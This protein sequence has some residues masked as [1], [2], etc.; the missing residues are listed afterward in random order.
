MQLHLKQTPKSVLRSSVVFE[1]IAEFKRMCPNCG[2]VIDNVRLQLGLPCPLCL[3]ERRDFVDVCEALRTSNKLKDLEPLCRLKELS[4]E[5]EA[6]F[7]EKTGFSPWKLQ[8]VWARRVFL[9]RSFSLIAPT[10]VGKSTW[11]LVMSCYIKGRVYILVPTKLL[12]MQTYDRLKALSP[13]K[14]VVAYTGKRTEKEKIFSGDFDILITTTNFLYRNEGKIPKP[15]DFV[16]V[17]D[18]DSL[19]KSAKNIDKVLKLLGFSQE[20][21]SVALEAVKL[22]AALA[23]SSSQV[24][25]R[26]LKK[27][28]EDLNA[29]RK[30][31]KGVLVVSSATSTPRSN[32]VKLFR[33]LLGFEVGKS[34]SFLRNVTDVLV[35]SKSSDELELAYEFLKEQ[36]KGVFIFVSE[37][38]GKPYVKTVVDFL[39]SRGFKV[40]SY[41]DFSPKKQE[42]FKKGL[43]DAV[44]GISSYKNPLARGIDIP[45]ALY[46]ALFIG[47]P[48][49]M[50]S[51]NLDL[52]PSKLF[53]VLLSLR[54]LIS[55]SE[56]VTSYLNFLKKHLYLKESDIDR[57]P[58]VKAE[59]EKIRD[60]LKDLLSQEEFIQKIKNSD[61]VF[62]TK[63]DGKLFLVVGDAVGYLQASGRVSRLFAGGLTKGV[64]LML[65][66]NLKAL[67][68]LKKRLRVFLSDLK[69]KVLDCCDGRELAKKTGL[70]I[71]DPEELKKELEKAKE[72]RLRVRQ[73]LQGRAPDEIKELLKTALVVVESPTKARTIASFFGANSRRRLGSLE[74]YEVNLGNLLLLLTAS[75]GHVF[76]LSLEEGIWGVKEENGRFVPVYDTIK[77]CTSCQE[78]TVSDVCPK[79]G[80]KPDSDKF[81][82]LKALRELSAEVDLLYVASDPDTEGEKIAWD[83]ALNLKPFVDRVKRLEFHEITPWAFKKALSEPRTVDENLVKA[84]IVR[85]VA[86]RWVGFSL[87]QRLWKVFKKHWLS[88]GRVQTP[89]LGWVIKRYDESKKKV[90]LISVKTHAGEFSFKT[91]K[92]ADE[93]QVSKVQILPLKE[94]EAEEKP[95]APFNTS[96][97]LKEADQQLGFSAQKTMQL[98]Q[99]LFERGLITYHRTDSVRV[100]PAGFAVA[101]EYISER[102]GSEYL[103][104]RVWQSGGA[105][106]CIRPTRPIDSL[107]LLSSSFQQGVLTKE[108]ER[109]YNLIF[110]RFIA[111]Q[112]TEVALLL[113]EAEIKLLP[114]GLKQVQTFYTK[115]LSQGFNLIEPLKLKRLSEFGTFKAL[116]VEKKLVPAVYPYTQGQLIEQMRQRGIGRPSTYAKIVQTLLQRNYVFQKGKFLVPTQLG[117]RVY[118]YLTESF[119][120]FTSEEFTRE[121]EKIMDEVESG[122]LDY[123][124]VIKD[125]KPVVEIIHE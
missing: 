122:K 97:L 69:F 41:E 91:E 54:E 55:E 115:I 51:L 96:S 26:R 76:D 53:G 117:R 100:S 95:P 125:L 46:W 80:K 106:E 98:A 10:G 68:S 12:L 38:K 81:D 75:K 47:V 64:S 16:F 27:L 65:V 17:D 112:M 62:I 36:K 8:L 20:D 25:L 63:K 83:V 67:N 52:L 22:K 116:S 43:I 94:Y 88:A 23:R 101:K 89:V 37:D 73:I 102:F 31:V 93:V 5:F 108:H 44:V 35:Y 29:I 13:N 9:K 104:L 111:S 113:V 114:S 2:S 40:I 48:K 110:R 1:K 74:A 58:S 103:K 87:S 61:D 57:F 34:A 79:C 105:H 18:V 70:E 30:R 99:E 118:S 107:F 32:R 119:P 86:D 60:F 6:F 121:L 42:E 56:F 49:L 66:D 59:L 15:F 4:A 124:D 92:K 39:N 33:E 77:L 82:V 109:L 21:I 24:L 85:R 11:G 120:E 19:L 50:F 7:K 78:Q 45:E 28:E 3:A 72:D 123:Q 90:A 84:Q 71:I 14:R